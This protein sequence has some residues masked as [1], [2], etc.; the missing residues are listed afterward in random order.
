MT[1][2]VTVRFEAR[3]A[4]AEAFKSREPEILLSGAAGTGKT[5]GALMKVHLAMLQYP[6]AR[7]LLVRK[8]LTSLTSSTLVAFRKMVAREAL[9]AGLVHFYGGSAQEP[10]AFRYKS[11]STIVV[12]SLEKSQRLLSTEYDFAFCDESVEVE[13]EDLDIIVT[14]LRHGR[15]PYQQLIMCTNPGGPSHHL[16]VRC[17]AGRTRMLYSR[18]EDN[19]RL[20]Q[21]GEWTEYG[22]T[23]IARLETLVGVRYQRM[24]WGKWVASENSVFDEFDPAVHVIDRFDIP[25]EWTRR[26][27]VDLGYVHPTAIGWWAEDPEGRLYLYRE[28][29]TTRKTVDVLAREMLREMQH[30]DGTWKEPK[31][32]VIVT[33]HDAEN[34]AVLERE[35]GMS[36]VPARKT[37]LDGIQAVQQRLRPQ[38]HDGKPRIFFFR[39][40]LLYRDPELVEAKRP[41]CTVEELPNYVWDTGAGKRAKEAPVKEMDDGCDMTRYLVAELDLGVSPRVRWLG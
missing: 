21:D 13:S 1:A 2:D 24:R 5:V 9:E 22:R 40:S 26:I 39:D 11:G 6:G 3:G 30:P 7:A 35:L 32:R 41:T 10:A 12:G 23:Y 16:K 17:D 31:P 33:D 18:H 20:F 4:V 25:D 29:F 34:R 28:I 37:V 19:P 8:T 15:L 36:T 38:P 27:S 14:R